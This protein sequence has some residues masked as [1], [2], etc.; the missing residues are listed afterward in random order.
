MKHHP[1]FSSALQVSAGHKVNLLVRKV[2]FPTPANIKVFQDY[3]RLFNSGKAKA[4]RSYFLTQF[5]EKVRDAKQTWS[6]IRELIGDCKNVTVTFRTSSP[7]TVVLFP[8][9]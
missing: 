6:L 8:A 4:K 2:K 3:N 5:R 1:W 9:H 7:K